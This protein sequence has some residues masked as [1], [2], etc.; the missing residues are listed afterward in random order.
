MDFDTSWGMLFMERK[1][2]V[3]WW[4]NRG[5]V[6]LRL[7]LLIE[8]WWKEEGAWRRS[9]GDQKPAMKNRGQSKGWVQRKLAAQAFGSSLVLEMGIQWRMQT[10]W[11]ADGFGGNSF[12]PNVSIVSKAQAER[13]LFSS[14]FWGWGRGGGERERNIEWERE[15]RRRERERSETERKSETE[16]GRSSGKKPYLY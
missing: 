9:W 4:N 7:W 14:R 3:C 5:T 12:N 8:V 13:T 11:V 16:R 15:G 1:L 2:T 10:A 6:A